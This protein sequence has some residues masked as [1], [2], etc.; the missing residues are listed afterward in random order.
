MIVHYQLSSHSIILHRCLVD[1]ELPG[2]RSHFFS[3]IE[4]DKLHLTID[5]F[6]FYNEDQGQV[7]LYLRWVK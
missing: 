5:A 4:D 1:S 7:R 3:R 2:S 6:K